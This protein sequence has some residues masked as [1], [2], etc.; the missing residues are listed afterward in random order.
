MSAYRIPG[1][2]GR[3]PVPPEE[4]VCYEMAARSQALRTVRQLG[5]IE[6]AIPT[7]LLPEFARAYLPVVELHNALLERARTRSR[8]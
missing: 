4:V 2:S 8:P 1:T 5:S 3:V 7:H 6:A